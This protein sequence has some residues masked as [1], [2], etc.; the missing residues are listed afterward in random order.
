[1]ATTTKSFMSRLGG[2]CRTG[3]LVL[4][5]GVYRKRSLSDLNERMLARPLQ[6]QAIFTAL[7]FSVLFAL[8]LLAAQFGW[9][10]ILVF[11]LV[12]IVL[13]N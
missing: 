8:C 10:G 1:M 13:V 3:A 2:L 6:E 12:I 4:F 9:I 11:W 7:V 5:A